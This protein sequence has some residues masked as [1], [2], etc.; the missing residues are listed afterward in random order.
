MDFVVKELGI[1]RM[2]SEIAKSTINVYLELI[3]KAKEIRYRMFD[4][5]HRCTVLKA[6]LIYLRFSAILDDPHLV[7]FWFCKHRSEE[8]HHVSGHKK[9]P[10]PQPFTRDVTFDSSVRLI[11]DYVL[12]DVS[13]SW[14]VFCSIY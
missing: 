5:H 11:S 9:Q 6:E 10:S 3:S 13:F 7:R 12:L 8:S 1:I 14:K 2:D 4:R